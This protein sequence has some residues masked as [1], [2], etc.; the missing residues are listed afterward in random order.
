MYTSKCIVINIQVYNGY[1]R[2]A[3]RVYKY[4]CVCLYPYAIPRTVNVRHGHGLFHTH[5]TLPFLSF[6]VLSSVSINPLIVNIKLDIRV[7]RGTRLLYALKIFNYL[8]VK[9]PEFHGFY[10]SIILTFIFMWI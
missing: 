10:N 1:I 2:T 7:V 5:H 4:I 3:N 6:S 8:A 9:F